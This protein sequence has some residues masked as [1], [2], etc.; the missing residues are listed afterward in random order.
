MSDTTAHKTEKQ[1]QR[2]AL[3]QQRAALPLETIHACVHRNLLA[4]EPFQQAQRVLCYTP[5]RN[6]I[7]LMPLITACSDKAWYLPRIEA[8]PEQPDER[9]MAFYR[10]ITG[11]PLHPGQYGILEPDP[12][13]ALGD[14][15][16]SDLMLIPGLAFDRQGVRLGYGKGY[17]DR[18]LSAAHANGAFPCLVGILPS[19][20][21]QDALPVDDWD[22]PMH[23]L[24]NEIECLPIGTAL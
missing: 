24:L 23:F 2:T 22:I 9:T 19:A 1:R 16:S 21:L 6:E 11:N 18:F 4:W 12:T 13:E 3:L 14:I 20:L 15:A 5:F 10:Y 17:Y 7:N 8:L